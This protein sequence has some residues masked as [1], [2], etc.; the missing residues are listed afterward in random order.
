MTSKGYRADVGESSSALGETSPPQA[1]AADQ[2]QELIK[3][4]KTHYCRQLHPA[5]DG[6][7][8]ACLAE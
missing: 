4:A 7:Y 5:D 1:T 3:A 2:Q 6:A 8:H